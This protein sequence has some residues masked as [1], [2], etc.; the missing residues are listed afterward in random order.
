MLKLSD[1]MYHKDT[2]CLEYNKPSLKGFLLSNGIA[3]KKELALKKKKLYKR[4]NQTL[5]PL[6]AKN[7]LNSEVEA[8][9]EKQEIKAKFE[10]LIDSMEFNYFGT[11][12]D[13]AKKTET[14]FRNL[15]YGQYFIKDYFNLLNYQIIQEGK[16]L[17]ENDKTINEKNIFSKIF[18]DSTAIQNIENYQDKLDYNS[19]TVGEAYYENSIIKIAERYNVSRIAIFIEY[20]K[21]NGEIHAHFLLKHP[22][23]Q[24]VREHGFKHSRKRGSIPTKKNSLYD[25]FKEISKIGKSQLELIYN[26]KSVRSYVTKYVLKDIFL[27]ASNNV[28]QPLTE[29]T[30]KYYKGQYK[31]NQKSYMYPLSV[32]KVDNPLYLIRDLTGSKKHPE[33]KC[34]F[35]TFKPFQKSLKLT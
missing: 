2:I 21:K 6:S 19:E 8:P 29:E 10:K 26:T 9:T 14:K 34:T 31:Y 32:E 15:I 33:I 17:L 16:R 7:F 28:L 18:N 12:T 25:F 1:N 13:R 35:G 27:E 5:Y 23:I 20:G 22:D 24:N 11:I 3:K 4:F 30:E